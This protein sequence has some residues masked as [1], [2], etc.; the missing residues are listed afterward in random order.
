MIYFINSIK[1]W[2]QVEL[3]S[4]LWILKYIEFKCFEAKNIMIK[5]WKNKVNTINFS[6]DIFN[7]NQ[8]LFILY[9]L[10]N[11]HNFCNYISIK[12]IILMNF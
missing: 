12:K 10:N 1:I 7:S 8:K 6:Y 2:F 3:K 9:F 11:Y 5:I 4:L